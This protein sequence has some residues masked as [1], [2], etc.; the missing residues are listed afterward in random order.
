MMMATKITMARKR[1]MVGNDDD[2]NHDNNN[3][4]NNNNDL[5]NNDNK[6]NGA[7]D[8]M[9]AIVWTNLVGGLFQ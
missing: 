7:D 8:N 5:N 3:D 2:D 1:V 6:D 4:R 9:D